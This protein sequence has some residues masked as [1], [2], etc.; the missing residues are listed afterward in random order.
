MDEE[1]PG[2]A[3]EEYFILIHVASVLLLLSQATHKQRQRV[4]GQQSSSSLDN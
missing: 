2:G 3:L 4:F 1:R